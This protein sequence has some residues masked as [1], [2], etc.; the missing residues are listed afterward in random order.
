M[1]ESINKLPKTTLNANDNVEIEI[2][3]IRNNGNTSNEFNL[4]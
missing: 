1:Y 4:G 2:N 3:Y